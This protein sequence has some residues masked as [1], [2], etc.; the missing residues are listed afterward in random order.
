[1]APFYVHLQNKKFNFAASKQGEN[2]Y[3]GRHIHKIH[4]SSI[5]SQ[6]SQVQAHDRNRSNYKVHQRVSKQE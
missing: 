1:M 4:K 6:H 2:T 3:R 5:D